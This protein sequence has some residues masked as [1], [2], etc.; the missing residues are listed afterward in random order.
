MDHA[1]LPE[2]MA[3]FRAERDVQVRAFLVEVTWQHRQPSAVS[4]LGE[5][6]LDPE[7][8]VWKEALDGLVTLASPAALEVLRSAR[9]R[10]FPD[11]RSAEEFRGWLEE[12]IAQAE[13][14]ARPS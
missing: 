1:V 8:V 6:L 9:I 14:R 3:V 10:Q 5:A 7:P 12:A 13:A 2:L 11:P 4:F